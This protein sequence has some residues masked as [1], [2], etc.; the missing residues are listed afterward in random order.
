MGNGG[1]MA[2]RSSVVSFHHFST[3]NIFRLIRG[4]EAASVTLHTELACELAGGRSEGR[5]G[6]L[7]FIRNTEHLQLTCRVSAC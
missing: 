4:R 3:G 6:H 5:G 2:P 7:R 1:H